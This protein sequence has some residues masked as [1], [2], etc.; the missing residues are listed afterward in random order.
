MP[1]ASALPGPPEMWGG[2]ECTVVRVRDAYRDQT[3]LNGHQDRPSDL[4]RFAE[5]GLRAIRYPVLW[6]RVA[7]DGLDR[8]DWRW[9]DERLAMLRDLGLRPIAGLVH[10]GSGPRET[11]LADPTFPERLAAYARAVAERYPWVEDWT[12]VNEPLTTARFSGLYGFWYPHATDERSC[13][14]MLVNQVRGV[15]LAMRAIRAINPRARLIQT[16]DL[17]R[18][19]STRTLAYQAAY[20][21]ERRWAGFDLLTGRVTR[22][23]PL[24]AAL[25]DATS[26]AVIEEFAEAPYP[27]DIVGLNHYLSGERFI[28]ERLERYPGHPVG[29][30]GRHRYI[31]C[32][33]LRAV[34]RGLAGPETLLEE[35][36][37]RYRIPIAVT[38]VHSDSSREQQIRWLMEIWG[39]ACR[40]R[41]RGVDVRAITAWSLLGAFDWNSL[42]QESNGFYEAG[43][44]D[45]RGPEPRPTAVAHAVRSLARTGTYDHPM[46]DGPGWW[47]R[48]DRFHWPRATPWPTTMPAGRM[49]R[50]RP[51]RQRR[52]LLIT[53]AGGALATAFANLCG[54]RD[55]GFVALGRDALDVADPASVAAALAEVRPWAVVNAAGFARVAAAVRDPARAT[56][57]NLRAAE[58]LGGACA[59]AGLPLLAFSSHLIFDGAKAEPYLERD[60]VGPLNTYAATKAASDEALLARHPGALL[61]R[62]G[63]FFGPWDGRNPLARAIRAASNGLP[64]EAP[65]GGLVSPTYL[66]DL[67]DFALNLLMDRETGLRHLAGDGSATWE[68]LIREA[69]RALGLAAPRVRRATGPQPARPARSALRSGYGLRLRTID[70]ALGSF[71]AEA[72]RANPDP[73]PLARER[74][75]A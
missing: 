16:E 45:I 73:A 1:P 27:P 33:A 34:T 68:D 70:G 4:H 61:L 39:A 67:A 75:A 51:P 20:E 19:L 50:H 62:P 69:L 14:R 42:L 24:R 40:L 44:F 2:V 32:P 63:P 17:G 49:R 10:H 28:D 41:K 60:A 38:E 74:D 66:P 5:L 8:A 59:D 21:N 15:R 26:E 25:V 35:A 48:G 7:P 72:R 56:R 47:Q 30:N 43:V 11:N 52:P 13:L 23:H 46:L 71:L 58:V 64:A 3:I 65:P 53:G 36:W 22:E 31:D 54:F 18:F 37:D 57:D 55:L 6:E 9:T 29:G 12:P